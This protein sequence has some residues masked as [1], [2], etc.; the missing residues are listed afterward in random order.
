MKWGDD[1]KEEKKKKKERE[2]GREKVMF[3]CIYV[4]FGFECDKL[5]L[6]C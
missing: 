2:E 5:I 6:I 3:R 1:K 4:G